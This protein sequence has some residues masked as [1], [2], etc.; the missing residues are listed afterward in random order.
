MKTNFS[1]EIRQ[2][3]EGANLQM[4]DL[5]KDLRSGQLLK[6]SPEEMQTRVKSV[7]TSIDKAIGEIRKQQDRS[8]AARLFYLVKRM[9]EQPIS[10]CETFLLKD[11]LGDQNDIDNALAFLQREA[12]S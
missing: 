4:I 5:V 9:N 8:L 7:G 6:E 3:L 10:C 12:T 11:T 1:K 2:H